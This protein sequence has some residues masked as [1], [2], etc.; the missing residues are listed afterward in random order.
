[1]GLEDGTIKQRDAEHA[2]GRRL[3]G[4]WASSGCAPVGLHEAERDRACAWVAGCVGLC[5]CVC[6]HGAG[7]SENGDE[8]VSTGGRRPGIRVSAPVPRSWRPPG[9]VGC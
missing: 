5:M 1:M 8:P 3:T 4:A 6:A 7:T 9:A 2:S